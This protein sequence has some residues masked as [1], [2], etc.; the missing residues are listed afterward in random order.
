MIADLATRCPDTIRQALAPAQHRGSPN[1]EQRKTNERWLTSY[2]QNATTAVLLTPE[3]QQA[4][5]D[6]Q[7]GQGG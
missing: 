4:R 7:R 6:Y 3:V 5:A 2:V 1:V